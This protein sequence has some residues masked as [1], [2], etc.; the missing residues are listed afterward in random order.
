MFLLCGCSE[1]N[2][3]SLEFKTKK[4]HDIEKHLN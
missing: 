3:K 4:I 2:E 1:S